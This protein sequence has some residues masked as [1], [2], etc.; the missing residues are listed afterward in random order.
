MAINNFR[1]ISYDAH[2][3]D[4]NY[5]FKDVTLENTKIKVQVEVIERLNLQIYEAAVYV[6]INI[7]WISA[8]YERKINPSIDKD[9]NAFMGDLKKFVVFLL[10]EAE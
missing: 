6:E 10:Q 2:P 5:C 7:R 9:Y 3:E 4:S 1:V 8:V